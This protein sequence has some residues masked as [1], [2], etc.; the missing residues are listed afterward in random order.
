MLR[1]TIW[2]YNWSQGQGESATETQYPRRDPS[3][4]TKLRKLQMT[5]RFDRPF[6]FNGMICFFRYSSRKADRE[7]ANITYRSLLESH[8]IHDANLPSFSWDLEYFNLSSLYSR[9]S[10]PWLRNV[11]SVCNNVKA[12]ASLSFFQKFWNIWYF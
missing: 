11:C 3:N 4:P 6:K 1:L 10:I 9:I 7:K 2:K 8:T 5:F 12:L